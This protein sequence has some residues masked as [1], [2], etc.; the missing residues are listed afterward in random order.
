MQVFPMFTNVPSPLLLLGTS[1]ARPQLRETGGS[2][3]L[4]T[5]LSNVDTA[6]VDYI[7]CNCG[8][9][10]IATVSRLLRPLALDLVL[11]PFSNI[12]FGTNFLTLQDTGN[13]PDTFVIKEPLIS[14]H[15]LED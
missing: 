10:I 14:R 9:V 7:C 15:L 1:H 6:D 12:M 4:F 11:L 3:C 2:Q 13:V 8:D 5:R